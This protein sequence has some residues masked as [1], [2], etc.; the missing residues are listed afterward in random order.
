MLELHL[1]QNFSHRHTDRQTRFPEIV[2]SCSGHPKTCKSIKNRK[3]KIFIKPILSSIYMRKVKHIIYFENN[4]SKCQCGTLQY[5]LKYVTSLMCV[6]LTK[7]Y[8]SLRLKKKM[9]FLYTKFLK[10]FFSENFFV[11]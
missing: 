11:F 8:I 2:E 1:P 7:S 3:S 10:T 5:V 6:F 4:S 9:R